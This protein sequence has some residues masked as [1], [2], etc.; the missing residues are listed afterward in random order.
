M[1]RLGTIARRGFLV[2]GAAIAGGV[3]FG[4]WAVR[5]PHANP[6]LG[7]LGPGEAALTPYVKITRAG[8]T[9][10][11]PRA[12]MGQGAYSIQAALIAEE[13]DVELDEVTVDPGPPSPGRRARPTGTPRSRPRACP[14]RRGTTACRPRRRGRSPGRG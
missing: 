8:V 4:V 5:R 13:L 7:E 2:G 1:S 11:T 3:A 9:L 10:I 14:S 6:L 12:D